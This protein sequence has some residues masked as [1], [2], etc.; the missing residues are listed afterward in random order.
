MRSQSCTI[1]VGLCL[2]GLKVPVAWRQ[3]IFVQKALLKDEVNAKCAKFAKTQSELQK[4]RGIED[5][6]YS[7]NQ[8]VLTD[9]ENNDRHARIGHCGN[10]CGQALSVD[11]RFRIKWVA[12]R[13]NRS[14]A[15]LTF[16]QYL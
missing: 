7:R 5:V 9:S 12:V 11:P 3:N 1:L 6:G 14:L 16:R 8:R 2:S 4:L 15:K 13:T 10:R